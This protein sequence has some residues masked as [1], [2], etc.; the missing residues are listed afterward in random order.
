MLTRRAH[1]FAFV[2]PLFWP[3]LWFQLWRLEAWQRTA[4]RDVL[5]RVDRFGNVYITCLGDGP[6]D[7]SLYTYT[8]P[9]VPA[10]AAPGLASDMPGDVAQAAL[11][12]APPCHT[13]GL[14]RAPLI[15]QAWRD[16]S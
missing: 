16:T 10:W 13:L 6:R 1:L 4:K 7:P 8:A 11:P 5:F 9:T 15:A 12:A 3:W 2:H 14:N